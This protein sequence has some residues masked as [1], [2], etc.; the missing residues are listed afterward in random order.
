M[1]NFHYYLIKIIGSATV[2]YLS[3]C[4]IFLFIFI[5][6][7]GHIDLFLVTAHITIGIVACSLI[8]GVR[9]GLLSQTIGIFSLISFS[10][11]PILELFTNTVYWGGG[12]LDFV[13]RINA[14]IAVTIFLIMFI[15]GHRTRFIMPRLYSRSLTSNLYGLKHQI[16]ILACSFLLTFYTLYLYEWNYLAFFFRGGENNEGLNVD[17]KSTF[18]LVEFFLRPLIFNIGLFLFFFCNNS[19]IIS[20]T[21]LIVGCFAIFPSGVP[22]FLAA[23]MYMPFIMHWAFFYSN[24]FTTSLHLPK[25]FL[26]NVL[27]AG[28]IFVFP[29]LDVFR[30]YSSTA[31]GQFEVFGLETILAGHFD[32]YQMLVRALDIGDLTYGYGFLGVFFFFI[33]RSLWATKPN[34]SGLE[35]A[36]KSNLYFDNVSMPLIGEFYLNFWYFGLIFLSFIF[37]V[38][39]KIIENN[40]TQK[41]KYSLSISW[42]IYFQAI[43]LLLLVLRGGLLSAFAYTMA[44]IVSWFCIFIFIKTIHIKL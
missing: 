35:V 10:C 17:L 22:R 43:G 4:S 42:I 37:G 20:L 6:N 5:N 12:Y 27:L 2:F 31:D 18:L 23:A 44:I 14:I 32:A 24:R 25:M 16:I 38:L 28:L 41:R 3:L 19:K 29:L 8:V 11:I 7:S 40:F 26:P 30:W 33:P 21:G 13:S 15:L 36:Q 39:I 9:Y 34:V 1:K